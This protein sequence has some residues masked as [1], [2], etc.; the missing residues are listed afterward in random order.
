MTF[1]SQHAVSTV[2]RSHAVKRWAGRAL[3]V[4]AA[5]GSAGVMNAAYAQAQG[6]ATRV[7]F[8]S[9]ERIIRDSAP[10][11]AAVARIDSEFKKRET[12]LQQ[13]ATRLR[14]QSEQ[15]DKDAAVMSESDRIRRQREL[16]TLDGEFQRKRI[17]FQEDL[18]RRRNEE[19]GRVFER[20]DQ[21]IKQI[22]ESQG[23]DL[24]LQ[25]AITV[26]PRV[27]ITDQ[28]IKAL[29]SQR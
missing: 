24:V 29:D 25:E 2:K 7:G 8:V 21:V 4:A 5:F 19:M 22:A 17:E 11:K 15:Y 1:L 10:A 18:N 12:E 23:Y 6:A 9:V 3:I 27:D 28:V 13:L 26:S 14:T 16:S 20:A